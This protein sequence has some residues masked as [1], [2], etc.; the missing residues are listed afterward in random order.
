MTDV[1]TNRFRS[2]A[3]KEERVWMDVEIRH[4]DVEW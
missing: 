2:A 4:S 3:L 1:Q